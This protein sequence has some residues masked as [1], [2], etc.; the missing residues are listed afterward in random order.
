[1]LWYG[2]ARNF[3]FLIFQIR[4]AHCKTLIS[5]FRHT[6]DGSF[7][8]NTYLTT[9][10]R[11]QFYTFSFLLPSLSHHFRLPLLQP[12]R[13]TPLNQPSLRFCSK[14]LSHEEESVRVVSIKKICDFELSR[15][16][17]IKLKRFFLKFNYA[18]YNSVFRLVY[19]SEQTSWQKLDTI[20]I[21]NFQTKQTILM[22]YRIQAYM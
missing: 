17:G 11:F 3:F 18:Q 10:R 7:A 6:F 16:R 19:S 21:G 13:L 15:F 5:F 14:L 22:L 9:T 4:N 1:M 8:V 12:R 20:Y 2:S